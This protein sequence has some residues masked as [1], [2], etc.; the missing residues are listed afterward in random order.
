MLEHDVGACR[1][2]SIPL[3]THPLLC[4]HVG[5]LLVAAE[6]VVINKSLI[7]ASPGSAAASTLPGY[8]FPVSK[9]VHVPIGRKLVDLAH[10]L[11]NPIL[12]LELNIVLQDEEH[13]SVVMI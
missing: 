8:L 13:I 3:V 12:A 1:G 11:L 2:N 4:V 10:H 7:L 6:L 5:C 9:L